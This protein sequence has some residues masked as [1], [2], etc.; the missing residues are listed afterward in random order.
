MS[1]FMMFSQALGANLRGLHQT[2]VANDAAASTPATHVS[3]GCAVHTQQD[4]DFGGNDILV[5]GKL[6]PL[7]S[8]SSDGCCKICSQTAACGGWVWIG[9]KEP[10]KKC[11]LWSMHITDANN[12]NTPDCALDNLS[13]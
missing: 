9:P 1:N 12:A 7:Q 6:H 4:A 8:N 5:D 11:L 2:D 3:A 10:Q 13:L